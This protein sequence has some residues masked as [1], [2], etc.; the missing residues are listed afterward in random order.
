MN[1]QSRLPPT[2]SS[3]MLI[4]AGR[5]GKASWKRKNENKHDF[6]TGEF[7]KKQAGNEKM[8]MSMIFRLGAFKKSKLEMKK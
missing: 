8:K 6:L 7:R 1:L 5:F 2:Y 4:F 3:W